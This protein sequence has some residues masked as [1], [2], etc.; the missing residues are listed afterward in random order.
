MS[1]IVIQE[2][3]SLPFDG[4]KRRRRSMPAAVKRQ[5]GK[6][7]SCANQWKRSGKR[8]KYQSFMKA[9]LKK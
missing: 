1:R 5:Q 8:G 2:G 3:Y 7:K 9:C 4:V 6:M